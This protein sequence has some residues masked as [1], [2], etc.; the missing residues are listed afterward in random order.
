MAYFVEDNNNYGIKSVL[1]DFM[2]SYQPFKW[3]KIKANFHIILTI[4]L[5]LKRQ[6]GGENPC[7]KGYF[8]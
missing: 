6:A 2:K 8:L 7:L 3:L 1:M 4:I 5:R